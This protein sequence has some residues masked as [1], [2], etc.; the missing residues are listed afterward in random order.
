MGGWVGFPTVA[1]DSTLLVSYF[2]A[3]HFV[4]VHGHEKLADCC[5]SWTTI[6]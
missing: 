1:I 6:C 3:E 5:L 2:V 4:G